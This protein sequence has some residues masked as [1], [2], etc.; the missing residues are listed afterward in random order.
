MYDDSEGKTTLLA[1]YFEAP[2]D[3][4][5]ADFVNHP[6]HYNA[7]KIECIDAMQD[8]FGADAVKDFC[9]LSA[10]K[11]IWRCRS[12]GKEHEDIKKAVW[13]LQKYLTLGA[14]NELQ[15]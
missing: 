9:L 1:D 10:F 13:Y 7:G 11:Y 4:S 12:K 15:E 5:A 6:A 2:D 3:D 8:V 14:A